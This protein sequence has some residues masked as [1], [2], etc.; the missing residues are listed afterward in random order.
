MGNNSGEVD[1]IVTQCDKVEMMRTV[2]TPASISCCGFAAP[3]DFAASVEEQVADFL[4]GRTHGEDLLHAL[5]DHVLDE[6]V[7]ERLRSLF[8]NIPPVK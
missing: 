2:P 5:Y 1:Q 3:E 8:K 6:P 7:P 4:D